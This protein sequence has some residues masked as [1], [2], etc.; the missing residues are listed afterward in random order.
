[1]SIHDIKELNINPRVFYHQIQ[2]GFKIDSV[3]LYWK[4]SDPNYTTQ[5]L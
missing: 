4:D 5:Q 3:S 2:L 1:L